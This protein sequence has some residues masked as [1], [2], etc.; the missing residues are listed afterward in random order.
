MCTTTMMTA[1]MAGGFFQPTAEL[2][3]LGDHAVMLVRSS[4]EF[5]EPALVRLTS[6]R[7]V[8]YC[9]SSLQRN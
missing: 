5:S 2:A 7:S 6:G 8:S 9:V 1:Q 4:T 3:R